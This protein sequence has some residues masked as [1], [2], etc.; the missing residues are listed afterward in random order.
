MDLTRT[1]RTL[2]TRPWILAG[3]LICGAGILLMAPVLFGNALFSGHYVNL[4][5]YYFFAGQQWLIWEMGMAPT[6]WPQFFSGYPI[7]FTLDGFFN[8][9]FIIAL[10]ITSVITAYHW[11]TF[12]FFIANAMAMYALARTLGRTPAAST[13]AAITYSCSGIMVRWLDV[14]VF[15]AIFFILPLTFI[16]ALKLYRREQPW[17]WRGIWALSLAYAWIGGFSELL[18][19]YLTAALLFHCYLLYQHK[20]WQW[21]YKVKAFTANYIAPIALSMLAVSP[22]LVSTA[23]FVLGFSNRSAGLSMSESSSM[24]LTISHLLHMINPRMVVPYGELI[25]Y[26]NLGSDVDLYIG[27][28]AT[29]LVIVAL[30]RWRHLPYQPFFAGLL[31]FAVLMSFNSPLYRLLHHIPPF[32][33]FRWHFKWSFITVFALAL[34]AAYGFD[35]MSKKPISSRR[36]IRALWAATALLSIGLLVI[37]LFQNTIV[38]TITSYG[39]ARYT[40]VS[41]RDLTYPAEYYESIIAQ[42]AQALVGAWSLTTVWTLLAFFLLL[43]GVGILTGYA[44]NQHNNK[45]WRY[46]AIGVV[47]ISSTSMWVGFLKG[48]PQSHLTKPPATARELHAREAYSGPPLTQPGTQPYRIYTFMP[49]QIIAEM[50]ARHGVDLQSYTLRREWE[51]EL[52]NDNIATWF[53]FDEAFSHEPLSVATLQE[54]KNLTVTPKQ[55]TFTEAITAFSQIET[56]RALGAMN[57][58]YVLSPAEL[59]E[60]WQRIYQTTVQEKLPVYIY[61]N[62]FFLPRWYISETLENPRPA[63]TGTTTLQWYG[64]GVLE[65]AVETPHEQWLIFNETTVPWWQATINESPAVIHHA[66]TAFQAIKLPAGTHTASFRLPDFWRISSYSARSLLKTITP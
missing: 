60:P 17:R 10:G 61:E 6:W 66:H 27:G 62:P 7:G 4:Y 21:W 20:E 16:A 51:R 64:P 28:L 19:Y 37:T 1:F 39:T 9:F 38:Q 59:H 24:P 32:T 48:M 52:L 40:Q 46:A 18:A 25:P 53:G 13:I 41:G 26:L 34:L 42:M 23:F 43:A 47:F 35:S 63:T 3:A 55:Q 50:Q 57:I 45:K 44:R 33:F 14:I 5:H 31:G 56:A 30:W 12:F 29:L 65:V 58:K 54:L 36:G 11:L 22:W 2:R 8:P 15:P 49:P